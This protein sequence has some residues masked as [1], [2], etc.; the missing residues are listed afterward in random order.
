MAHCSKC[1]TEVSSRSRTGLC[2]VCQKADYWQR[3]YSQ[4][5]ATVIQKKSDRRRSDPDAARAADKAWREKSPEKHKASQARYR[6]NHR[7]VRRERVRA[8]QVANPDKVKESVR[9][10][11]QKPE[12]VAA[13]KRASAKRRAALAECSLSAAEWLAIK[14]SYGYCCA[15][16]GSAEDISQDHVVPLSKGGAHN[17]D[18][19]QPL[20]RS[21]NSGKRNRNAVRYA[22]WNGQTAVEIGQG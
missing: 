2:T 12:G 21:C 17:A 11:R 15:K 13:K 16:C 5:R 19:I 8:W 1:P 4:N 14:A 7:E 18:N 22:P 6:E 3:W 9:A 20:C 10:Y